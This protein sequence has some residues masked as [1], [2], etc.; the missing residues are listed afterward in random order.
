MEY[1]KVVINTCYGG[2][3][4]SK[5]GFDL[6][7][8]LTGNDMFSSR[9]DFAL[10][11]VVDDLGKASYGKCAELTIERIP[12]AFKD[13]YLIDEYDGLETIDL[14]SNLLIEHQLSQL[15]VV[16]MDPIECKEILLELQKISVINYYEQ[17]S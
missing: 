8:Q 15:D 5:E 4:L 17:M 11:K 7:K 12:M 13:C 6:Y 9:H 3:G 16:N 2:F 1:I 10:V 14:S